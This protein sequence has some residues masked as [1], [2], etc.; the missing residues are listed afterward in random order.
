MNHLPL[1]AK[2]LLRYPGLLLVMLLTV[3]TLTS[4]EPDD[5]NFFYYD[6]AGRWMEVAPYYGDIYDFNSDGTGYCYYED[7]D[8]SYFEWEADNYYLT[9]Y[10]TNGYEETVEYY[11][12][13]FQGNSL[14]LY[15]NYDTSN[16]LVLKPY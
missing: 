14:Y 9:L 1:P 11:S 7:G 6:I 8:Y 3:T 13:S 5:D 12:W 4:C 2:K 16:P 10:F 15:P